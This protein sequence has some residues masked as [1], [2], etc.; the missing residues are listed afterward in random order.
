MAARRRKWPW[1]GRVEPSVIEAADLDAAVAAGIIDADT[2]DRLLRF[3]Q[4]LRRDTAVGPDEEQFR[5]LTSFN[6][7]FVTIAIGLLL[8]AVGS[9]TS[10]IVPV[11][12]PPLLAAISWGLAEY[13]TRKRRMALPSV[14]LLLSFVGSAFATAISVG[15]GS[16][17]AMAA[18]PALVSMVAAGG[19]GI[20]AAW[21]HWRRFMVPITIAAGAGA[22]ASVVVLPG[23]AGLAWAL[24]LDSPPFLPMIALCGLG[25]FALAMWYDSRDLARTTR[26]SDV[27]FWLHLLA[28]PMIIHPVFAAAGLADGPPGLG[29]A[30]AIVLVYLL[31]TVL[32]L[33]I[34]RRALI[35]SALG[36][37]I[38]AIQ[39][40]IGGGGDVS[41]AFGV[42]ALIIGLF[43]VLLSAA[44]RTVRGE[45]LLYV[46]P[47]LRAR[48]PQATG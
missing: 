40:L 36:Y 32:A 1:A 42:T 22:A 5:L 10:Q 7:I 37:V 14:V 29:S 12:A 6:D 20:A 13:F 4:D 38:Y 2:R 3:T 17:D 43:L 11:L 25:V 47:R 26:R 35:V 19:L 30:L 39:A 28:A 44:W 46:P 15:G 18:T 9:L 31:L 41:A 21:L 24:K 8:F 48:L 45:L 16:L 34:D 23:T 33:A 27:A